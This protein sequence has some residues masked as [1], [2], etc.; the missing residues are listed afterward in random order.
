MKN[1]IDTVAD[2]LTN[3]QEK[4]LTDDSINGKREDTVVDSVVETTKI[5]EKTNPSRKNDLSEDNTTMLM[6]KLSTGEENSFSHTEIQSSKDAVAAIKKSIN[7]PKEIGSYKIISK[8]GAGGM[9][10]VYKAYDEKLRRYVALKVI[11]RENN[12]QAIERFLREAYLQ[13]KVEHQNV[14]KIYEISNVEGSPFIAMQF[15]DGHSLKVAANWMTL[16]QKLKVMT[17]V[18]LAIHQAHKH[19]LIHRDIKPDNIMVESNPESNWHPYVVDFGLAKEQS[20]EGVTITGAVVGTPQYMSPEQAKGE[21][22]TLDR[23]TDIY[24]LGATLYW[25]TLGKAPFDGESALKI[26]MKIIRQE[27]PPLRQLDPKISIDLETIIMKCLERRPEQRYFSAKILAQELERYLEG[28]PIAARPINLWQ[29]LIRKARKHRVIAA[30]ITVSTILILI[31]SIITTN[32]LWLS[33]KQASLAQEL[34]QEIEKMDSVMRQAA[35]LPLHKTIAEKNFVIGRLELIKN[36]M[37]EGGKSGLGPGNYALGR[38]FIALGKYSEASEHLQKAWD[39]GY[40]KRE[41]AYFLGIALGELYRKEKDALAQL[42]AEEAAIRQEYIE[43]TYR[44]QAFHYLQLGQKGLDKN[45]VEYGEVEYGEALINFYLKNWQAAI[46]KSSAASKKAPWL[47]ET[48]KLVARS[49]IELSE[50]L[51]DIG[52]FAEAKEEHQKAKEQY[53]SLMDIGKSDKSLYL[54]QSDLWV[55]IIDLDIRQG[56]SPPLENINKIVELS[57]KAALI[58]PTDSDPYAQKARLYWLFGLYKKDNVQ[59]LQ[60]VESVKETFNKSI[61]NAKTAIN[62]NNLNPTFYNLGAMALISLGDY[63]ASLGNNPKKYFNEAIELCSSALKSHPNYI[64]C[65]V[66]I[67]DA[68]ASLALYEVE[69]NESPEDS[70]N[71]AIEYYQKAIA[72]NPNYQEAYTNIANVYNDLGFYTKDQDPMVLFQKA[73]DSCK[74]ALSLNPNNTVANNNLGISYIN[75]ANYKI[76]HNKDPINSLNEAIKSYQEALEINP[77]D[78]VMYGNLG[79]AYKLMVKHNFSK[80][81]ETKNELKQ[82]EEF[83]EKAIKINSDYWNYQLSAEIELLAAQVAIKEKLSPLSYLQKAELH[84]QKSIELN[85]KDIDSYFLLAEI[86]L[87]NIELQVAEKKFNQGLLTKLVKTIEKVEKISPERKRAKIWKEIVSLLT[88]EKLKQPLINLE[89]LNRANELLG[90]LKN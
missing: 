10:E 27:P 4:I 60:D 52:K 29:R 65:K 59:N 84:L 79:Y 2:S 71:K 6:D 77:S 64:S 25:L 14:C 74:K 22:R 48:Q 50:E 80:N 31:F 38:G 15:I 23:R 78:P 58:D 63:E 24:S 55:S 13:A 11:R 26:V 39:S 30:T 41:V 21:V 45:S 5:V 34:G 51:K 88:K 16:E 82:A 49:Y 62:L 1:K 28:E 81:I 66:S 9:G 85:D 12:S 86:Y 83:I 35:L 54:D 18:C 33:S 57:D 17:K 75:I 53:Q 44:L 36:L 90:D 76:K 19:G 40:K 47:Y 69:E 87:R 7:I 70:L 43:K 3:E 20:N 72:Q 56:I 32:T 8:L 73:I 67:G 61:E 68:Y 46:E 37:E 42:K 89:T